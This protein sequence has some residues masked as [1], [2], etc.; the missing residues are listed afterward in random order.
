MCIS[1][2]SSDVCSSDLASDLLVER[3]V[4]PDPLADG[5]IRVVEEV[6][7]A[8]AHPL[9]PEGGPKVAAVD[10]AGVG[11]RLLPPVDAAGAR[12]ALG[13]E[14]RVGVVGPQLVDRHAMQIGRAHV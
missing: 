13:A 5:G 3:L 6:V 4:P 7:D 14:M 9:V 8:L 1:D 2:W 10:G 11:Q 12:V